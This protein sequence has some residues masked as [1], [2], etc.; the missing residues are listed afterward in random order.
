MMDS[1][2][3]LHH[4]HEIPGQED[5]VKLIGVYASWADAQAV[6]SRLQVQPG[7]RDHREGFKVDEYEIGKDHWEEGFISA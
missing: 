6:V 1:V 4:V 7:F 5:D 3:V 2:F